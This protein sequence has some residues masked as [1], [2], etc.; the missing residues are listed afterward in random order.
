MKKLKPITPSELSIRTLEAAYLDGYTFPRPID[1]LQIDQIVRT[2]SYSSYNYRL[3]S[4]FGTIIQALRIP[5]MVLSSIS[6]LTV[7]QID[8]TLDWLNQKEI[9]IE[10]R[11]E[12]FKRTRHVLHQLMPVADTFSAEHVASKN[13][14]S[15][16]EAFEV[17]AQ[18]KRDFGVV[19]QLS[20]TEFMGDNDSLNSNELI[21]TN[22]GVRI[23]GTGLFKEN[24]NF[25]A[26]RVDNSNKRFE[27]LI[28]RKLVQYN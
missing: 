28:K 7:Q 12:V 15:I 16:D 25:L 17:I 1:R 11:V 2:F 9:F 21:V 24:G 6:G 5:N 27:N 22:S 26:K 19:L 10:T 8:R 4:D 23:V 14:A 18:L 3:E 20:P 13:E